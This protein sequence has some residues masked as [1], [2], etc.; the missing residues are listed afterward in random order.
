MLI[1]LCVIGFIILCA[2]LF[3]YTKFGIRLYRDDKEWI[4]YILNSVGVCVFF[5]SLIALIIIGIIYS[6]HV[7][8]DDKIELYR[9][10]NKKIEEQMSVII[11]NYMD[12]ESETFEK[13]KNESSVTLVS[14]F[15]DLKSNELVSKQIELYIYNTDIIKQLEYEKLQYKVYAWWLFFGN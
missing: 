13:L 3:I 8:I 2:G 11:D 4:Y 5:V 10:E 1:I 15:P 14:L 12:Y 6:N 9:I 7:I